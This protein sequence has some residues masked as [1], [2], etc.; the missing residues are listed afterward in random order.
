[1]RYPTFYHTIQINGLSIFYR[2]AGQKGAPT[3]VAIENAGYTV[4]KGA[5]NERGTSRA[6][7]L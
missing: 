1:M 4:L 3:N 5:I 6:E 2:E 7:E